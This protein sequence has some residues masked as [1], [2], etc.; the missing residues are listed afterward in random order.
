MIRQK[1]LRQNIMTTT[2]TKLTYWYLE[3]LNGLSE[4]SETEF[5]EISKHGDQLIDA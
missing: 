2:N 1:F 4:V 5:Q 3:Y